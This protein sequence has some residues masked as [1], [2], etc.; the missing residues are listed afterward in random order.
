LNLGVGLA[1]LKNYE[2]WHR[3][4]GEKSHAHLELDVH[5]LLAG[6]V[7][8]SRTATGGFSAVFACGH[9]RS[10]TDGATGIVRASFATGA[11]A[12]N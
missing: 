1:A 3:N 2:T 12:A 11:C 6:F 9:T 8:R 7:E 10:H 4:F 5:D